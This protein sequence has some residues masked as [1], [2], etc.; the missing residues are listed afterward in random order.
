MWA[1]VWIC[2]WVCNM[3]VLHIGDASGVSSLIARQTYQVAI[4]RTVSDPYGISARNGA[5]MIDGGAKRFWMNVLKYMLTWRPD[6][7]HVHNITEHVWVW[8]YLKAPGMVWHGHGSRTRDRTYDYT[9]INELF[10]HVLVS[11]PEL[12]ACHPGSSYLPNPIDTELFHPRHR[13]P[14]SGILCILKPDQSAKA[15]SSWL[16][17]AGYD[18]HIHF[19]TRDTPYHEMPDL[20][21]QYEFFADVSILP[22]CRVPN[23]ADS[24]TGLQARSMGIPTITYDGTIKDTL[25]EIHTLDFVVGKLQEIYDDILQL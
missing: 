6:I 21:N 20:L 24:L 22:G 13:N 18:M 1:A 16:L 5:C 17:N 15:T 25:P 14:E 2:A 19:H 3:K 23:P 12:V 7:I 9:K 4:M 11:T 10:D 8:K